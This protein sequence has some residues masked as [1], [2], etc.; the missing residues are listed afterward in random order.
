MTVWG[1]GFNQSPGRLEF[2]TP[3][4]GPDPV[5]IIVGTCEVNQ[6]KGALLFKQRERV[7]LCVCVC[8]QTDTQHLRND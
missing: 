8:V 1:L 7:S 6:Q 2:L 3:G 4:F 5:T